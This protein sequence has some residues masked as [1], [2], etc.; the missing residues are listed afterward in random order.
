MDY[1]VTL[2][3]PSGG[4]YGSYGKPAQYFAKQETGWAVKFFLDTWLLKNKPNDLS[5]GSSPL[6]A[7]VSTLA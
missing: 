5:K 7:P 4:F 3:N 6:S 2:Q 1:L